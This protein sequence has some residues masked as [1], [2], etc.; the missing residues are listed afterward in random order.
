MNGKQQGLLDQ[1]MYAVCTFLTVLLKQNNSPF[2]LAVCGSTAFGSLNES[3]DVELFI[4]ADK[5]HIGALLDTPLLSLH[6]GS[7]ADADVVARVATEEIDAVRLTEVA[8]CG[9][10]FCIN[11]Y[12][13]DLCRKISTLSRSPPIKFRDQMKQETVEFRSFD[14]ASEGTTFPYLHTSTPYKNGFLSSTAIVTT[15]NGTPFFHIYVDKFLT[16]F[17]IWDELA[18]L[19]DQQQLDKAL[20]RA[21]ST[22]GFD[23][24]HTF[25]YRYNDSSI[26]QRARLKSRWKHTAADE[27]I[28]LRQDRICQIS[29]PPGVGK[30]TVMTSLTQIYPNIGIVVPYTTKA[31]RT[32]DSGHYHFVSESTFFRMIS[33]EQFL[34]WHYDGDDAKGNAKYYGL[35]RDAVDEAVHTYDRVL[36]SIGR[37]IAARFFKT[38]FP[39]AKTIF[40][41][42]ESDDQ[43]RRQIANRGGESKDELTL[44]LLTA[45]QP[46]A[47]SDS[48]FDYRVLNKDAHIA[49]TIEYTARLIGVSHADKSSS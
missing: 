9:A 29:G 41:Y 30:D 10:I 21:A 28:A 4:V 25:L 39:S 2:S 43:L 47:F 33:N 11:I 12:T 8:Y 27:R 42:P 6:F 7:K 34:F 19:A 24:P 17:I 23:N 44:R 20:H 40:L 38:R 37:S 5:S 48:L 36:F 1:R 18:I 26:D 31:I 16:A 49:E 46:I 35:T 13:S 45:G 15:C 3:S 32:T 22:S 14:Y